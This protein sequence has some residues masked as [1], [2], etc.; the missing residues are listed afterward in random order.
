MAQ[1][2]YIDVNN[3]EVDASTK[4]DL[5]RPNYETPY[6]ETH[7]DS[8]KALLDKIFTYIDSSTP[9][10][11]FDKTTKEPITDYKKID[12]NSIINQGV[13]SITNYIWGVMYSSLLSATKATGG[14]RYKDYV[15]HRFQFLAVVAPN[16]RKYCLKATRRPTPRC[17]K[18]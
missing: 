17:V 11:V 2:Q 8:V 15:E 7:K 5:S 6:G 12:E 14:E 18:Y 16:S 9:I 1:T 10:G 3:N 13:F 4:L